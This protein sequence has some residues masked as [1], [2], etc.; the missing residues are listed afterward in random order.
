MINE[1]LRLIRRFHELTQTEMA[2]RLGV[3]KSYLNEVE[4]GHKNVTLDLLNRY[5]EA[6]DIPMSHLM[7]F[8]EQV[9]DPKPVAKLKRAI[10]G[11]TVAMLAW[12]ERQTSGDEVSAKSTSC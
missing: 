7:L 9:D 11:K 5:S 10:A 3:S 12:V 8:A 2:T 6:L 1:A 4:H